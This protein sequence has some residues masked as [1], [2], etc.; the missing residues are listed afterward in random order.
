MF[1]SLLAFITLG[2]VLS[3]TGLTLAIIALVHRTKEAAV[4]ALTI[5]FLGLAFIAA[6]F[7]QDE[8]LERLLLKYGWDYDA[9]SQVEVTK[10]SPFKGA[11]IGV[12]R[13][14]W[15]DLTLYIYASSIMVGIALILAAYLA[16]TVLGLEG[17]VRTGSIGLVTIAA[18]FSIGLI[19][20]STNALAEP[21]LSPE[22][23]D[24][25]IFFR[26][27]GNILRTVAL[28]VSLGALSWGL[29]RIHRETGERAYV[30]QTVGW[31]L[32]LAG[33]AIFGYMSTTWWET[34]EEAHIKET[35]SVDRAVSQFQLVALL[36]FLGSLL[37]LTGSI[38]ELIPSG[39]EEEIEEITQPEELEG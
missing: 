33:L 23:R 7:F 10:L 25:A 20:V 9:I 29:Y 31:L 13:E 39:G 18:V 1:Y 38:L 3:L 16:V 15:N 17:G 32:F 30:I 26:D 28:V 11:P 36:T 4:R 5:L 35:L 12:T 2:L 34:A 19:V 24:R 8:V 21:G 6:F 27:M 14:A 37:L 22:A